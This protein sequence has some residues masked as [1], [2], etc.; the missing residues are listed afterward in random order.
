MRGLPAWARVAVMLIA[1]LVLGRAPET[2]RPQAWSLSLRQLL[3]V[4][5][6][7]HRRFRGVVAPSAPWVFAAPSI[8]FAVL[9]GL[10]RPR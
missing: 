7:A 2:I 6:A 3:R 8:A 10:V 4:P 9:P 5:S 1:L